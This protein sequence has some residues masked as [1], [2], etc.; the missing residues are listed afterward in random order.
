M[1]EVLIIKNITREGSGIIENVLK[2]RNIGFTIIDLDK[3]ESFPDPTNYGAVFI[4]G[5][6]DSAND[7][8]EK[9]LNELNQVKKILEAQ[10]PYFGICLGLQ[11]L[12]KAAGGKVTKSPLKEVGII[13]PDNNNFTVKLTNEG[14]KDPLFA[15]INNEFRVFHLHGETVEITEKMK[16][17]AEGKF[18][19]NQIVKV[20]EKAYGIQS[21][22]ELTL[23]A[24]EFLITNAPDL[25]KLDTNELRSNFE[26]IK[27]EY[28]KNGRRVF[29]NFLDIAGY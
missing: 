20:A 26:K 28:T 9:I 17:L 6:P 11:L 15:N 14:S 18:C 7:Q 4:L 25:L 8:N 1:K 29:S 21:H 2:E 27:T 12:V 10:I 5:G 24:F 16:L 13:D 19:K 22:L 23:E 3:K